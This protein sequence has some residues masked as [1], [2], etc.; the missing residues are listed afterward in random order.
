MSKKFPRTVAVFDT[1]TKNNDCAVSDSELRRARKTGKLNLSDKHLVLWPEEILKLGVV[2]SDNNEIDLEGKI[3]DDNY[4]WWEL[5]PLKYLDLS[6]NNIKKIPNQIN[7]LDGLTTLLLQQNVVESLPLELGHLRN[8]VKLDLG[9]NKL[10]KIPS[11]LSSLKELRTLNLSHNVF[12]KFPEVIYDLVMLNS[13]D[14]SSNIIE[15]MEPGIGFLTRVV[16]LN[17]SHNKLSSI[18]NDITSCK[19]LKDLNMSNN[20]LTSTGLPELINMQ[21][22]EKIQLQYNCLTLLPV[23]TGCSELKEIHLGFNEIQEVTIEELSTL[24]HLQVINLRNNM[25]Q[26]LPKEVSC[27][28]NLVRLDLSNNN[29]KELPATLSLLPHLE[30]LLVEGNSLRS[31]RRD[32]LHGGTTRLINHLKQLL[33]AEELEKN[34]NAQ[35]PCTAVNEFPDRYTMRCSRAVNLACKDLCSIP[36]KVFEEAVAVPCTIVDLSKNKLPVVP[37]GVWL[38]YKTLTDLNLANNQLKEIPFEIKNCA[39]LRYLN[40][41]NNQLK[42]LPDELGNCTRIRELNISCNS[43]Q[44]IPESVYQL[45]AVEILNFSDNKITSL[46]AEKMLQLKFLANLDLTNNNLTNVPPLIG[47]M[48]QLR[49]FGL[50]GN[51]LRAL[52]PAIL[53]KGTEAVLAWLRNKIV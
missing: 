5:E 16:D 43:I 38:L 42:T 44:E 46:D 34:F 47:N 45:L 40:V 53:A 48:K 41:A 19:A 3:S 9:Y 32:I 26:K 14:I 13:L 28:Q 36:D 12:K 49:S 15:I 1:K 25:L 51:G 2:H 24:S 4:K 29:L 18:P 21:N 17:I 33:P 8:L 23:I 35:F 6:S 11:E 39:N 52:R 37:S 30:S 20:R 27:L 50:D 31:I 7:Q 10:H 22:I